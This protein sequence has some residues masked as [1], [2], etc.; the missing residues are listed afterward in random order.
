MCNVTAIEKNKQYR[1]V[2]FASI[3]IAFEHKI[4][5]KSCHSEIAMQGLRS[6]TLSSLQISRK[7]A[8]KV[9]RVVN[10]KLVFTDYFFI[11]W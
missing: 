4:K 8:F 3:K 1:N 6:Q 7:R 2:C 5:L 11:I 9:A 10:L